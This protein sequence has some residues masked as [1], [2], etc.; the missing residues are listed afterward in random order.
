M[1]GGSNNR[2]ARL[3]SLPGPVRRST[4]CPVSSFQSR[5]VR[6]SHDS[7]V[8]ARAGPHPSHARPPSDT[9][10][11][12][13]PAAAAARR[14]TSTCPTGIDLFGPV[15]NGRI[16]KRL[17]VASSQTLVALSALASSKMRIRTCTYSS[18]LS[19]VK[20]THSFRIYSFGC[21]RGPHAV[22]AITST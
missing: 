19:S 5:V 7:P 1:T 17:Q 21:A 3:T 2:P 15:A 13:G 6:G 20:P 16:L 10:G 14:S 18:K 4:V 11:G 9:P 12:P 8:R 22:G